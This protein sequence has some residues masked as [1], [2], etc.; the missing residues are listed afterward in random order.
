METKMSSSQQDDKNSTPTFAVLPPV[1]KM[2]FNN[3]GS[4]IMD[5]QN[6]DEKNSSTNDDGNSDTNN[7]NASNNSSS[8]NIP[9]IYLSRLNISNMTNSMK[10]N[11][12]NITGATNRA[13]NAIGNLLQGPSITLSNLT[14]RKYT[15]PDRSTAS[16]VLMFRQLLHTN[17]KPG[18]R[19]SRKFQGTTRKVGRQ[20]HV[21]SG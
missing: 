18:L 13:T 6:M 4:T 2:L 8:S 9:S 16:Q 21:K 14:T 5:K 15:L 11:M 12:S 17:C 20:K 19:L 7:Q 1:S 3:D 10:M